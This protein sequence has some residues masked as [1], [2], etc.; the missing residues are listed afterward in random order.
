MNNN[1]VAI[2][3]FDGVVMDTETIYTEFWDKKGKEHLGLDHFGSEVKGQS[4]DLIYSRYFSD[5]KDLQKVL[6]LEVIDLDSNMDY[7]YI[8]GAKEAMVSLRKAGVPI[9]VVTGSCDRKMS[10]V[11]KMHPDFRGLTDLIITA[12]NVTHAKPN[13]EGFLLAMER[14]NAKPEQ[15]VVFEDSVYGL[16]AAREAG[17]IVVG[18]V[19]TNSL[20]V[21]EPLSDYVLN[22][23]EG[24]DFEAFC[25]FYK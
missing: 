3:D 12:D 18:L 16:Q 23:F 10:Y 24:V 4:L 8:K 17:T 1:K 7:R 6:D 21:V 2:F 5:R 14:L 15:V 9:A 22:D 20:E 11:D 19:T 25:E 13:P